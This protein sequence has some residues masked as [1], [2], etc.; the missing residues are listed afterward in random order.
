MLIVGGCMENNINIYQQIFEKV[1]EECSKDD[2]LD[3][4]KIK[5]I[6]PMIKYM[7]KN[8]LPYVVISIILIVVVVSSIVCC[9]CMS[10][11]SKRI[12]RNYNL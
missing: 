3:E 1:M 10:M 5:I 7:G 11:Q 2:N 9:V 6:D 12:E 4:L 8:I